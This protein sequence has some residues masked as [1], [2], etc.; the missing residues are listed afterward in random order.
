MLEHYPKKFKRSL[1]ENISQARGPLRGLIC[2]YFEKNLDYKSF[3]FAEDNSSPQKLIQEKS[4]LKICK[5]FAV[6][7]IFF[8]DLEKKKKSKTEIS[9]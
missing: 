7:R 5:H 9:I 2:C 8:S 4:L 3:F 6:R 1:M